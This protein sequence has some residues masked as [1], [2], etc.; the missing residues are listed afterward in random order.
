[1]NVYQ[2]GEVL[3]MT[4]LTMRQLDYWTREMFIL[5][6]TGGTGSGDPRLWTAS[7]VARIKIILHLGDAGLSPGA[8]AKFI[9]EP[10]E[11]LRVKRIIAEA[12]QMVRIFEDQAITES[13]EIVAKIIEAAHE[14]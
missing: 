2:T 6:E 4:G 13:S 12:G 1:V 9:D 3:A 14:S 8:A 7:E 5:P 11:R 10:D